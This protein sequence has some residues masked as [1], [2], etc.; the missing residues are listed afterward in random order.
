MNIDDRPTDR[1]QG[2]FTHFAKISNCHNS[3]TC[4][5]IHFLFGSRVG[6]MGT[7]DRMTLFPVGSSPRWQLVA[8]LKKFKWPYL[9]NALS[10]SL[11]VFYIDHTLPLDTSDC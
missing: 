10:D 11:Y 9:C 4:Q 8:M 7:A 5:L 1:P 6:F 2:L 3:A